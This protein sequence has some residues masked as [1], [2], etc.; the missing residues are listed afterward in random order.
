MGFESVLPLIIPYIPT[1]EQAVALGRTLHTAGRL[2]IYVGGI[3]M[4][5]F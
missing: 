2:M 5:L 3:L 4:L 1:A